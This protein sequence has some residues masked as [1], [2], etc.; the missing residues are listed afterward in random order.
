VVAPFLPDP[1]RT[2]R[3]WSWLMRRVVDGILYVLWTVCARAHLLL[4]FPPSGTG[5]RWFL[6]LSRSGTFERLAHALAMADREHVGC[7]ASPTAAVLDAQ[8]ARSGGIGMTGVC[9]YTARQPRWYGPPGYVALSVA[10]PGPLL[11]RPCLCRIPCG[12]C[13]ACY[14]HARRQRARAKGL[15]RAAQAV[16]R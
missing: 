12:P 16:S 13:L 6:R 8:S 2:G 7:D 14:R 4:D 11:R 15:C 5:L 1:A 9:G 10:V 3:P